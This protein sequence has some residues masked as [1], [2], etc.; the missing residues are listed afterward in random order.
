MGVLWS[1]VHFSQLT[2]LQLKFSA[3]A[4]ARRPQVKTATLSVR[5]DHGI[6]ATAEA[7]AALERRSLTGLL[8]ILIL[9]HCHTLGVSPDSRAKESRK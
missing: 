6:K 2:Q 1:A 5:L 4:P 9:N 3:M 7:A 8:E